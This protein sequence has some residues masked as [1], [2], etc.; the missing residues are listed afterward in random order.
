MSG[1]DE[2][3]GH[4]RHPAVGPLESYPGTISGEPEDDVDIVVLSGGPALTMRRVLALVV[5][6]KQGDT[7]VLQRS[8]G[9]SVELSIRVGAVLLANHGPCHRVDYYEA[10]IALQGQ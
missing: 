1:D 3:I 4:P 5:E 9:V 10:G 8:T 2:L 7:S 6:A